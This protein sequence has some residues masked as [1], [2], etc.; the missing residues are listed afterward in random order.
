MTSPDHRSPV[1]NPLP[2]TVDNPVAA[3]LPGTFHPINPKNI[4]IGNDQVLLSIWGKLVRWILVLLAIVVVIVGMNLITDGVYNVGGF[5]T[6]H[7][8]QLARNPLVGLLIGILA[9]AVVQSSTTT[10][11][12]TVA[13]VGSGLVSVP[14]AVPLIMGANIGTTITALIVAFSY[15]G[16]R[17][18]FRLAFSTA[19]MHMW[20]KILVVGILAPIELILHPLQRISSTLSELILGRGVSTIPT[21]G[22]IRGLTDPII[23]LI[24]MNGL[25][26]AI[27]SDR[28][29]AV[30][31][32]VT[33]SL[34]IL[35]AVRVMS[36]QLRIITAATAHTLMDF[37]ATA[38]GSPRPTYR[39]SF[40]GFGAGALFTVLVTASSVTVASMLPFAVSGT[41]KR[42]AILPVILGANVGTT[43]TALLATLAV[44]GDNGEFALRAA[45][46]HVLINLTGA[47][48]VLGIP[49]LG[50]AICLLSAATAKVARRSYSISLAVILGLY[51]AVP[52]LVLVIYT[53]VN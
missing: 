41:M 16:D 27:G 47:L 29:A 8:Y 19:A 15:V 37:F 51:I 3:F 10:T 13:A 32:L 14:V 50:D 36:N 23:D 24:G 11:T 42:R 2:S 7:L 46:I 12:L 40:L 21:T 48:V 26:G 39:R 30:L 18:E 4:P 43:L 1:R 49:K 20:F 22:M 6:A 17:R 45:L 31:C 38:P 33:G 35:L 5:Q 25:F 53:M 28:V 44:V 34:F 9:T 52:A